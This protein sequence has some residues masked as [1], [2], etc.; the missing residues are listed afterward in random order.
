MIVRSLKRSFAS[1]MTASLVS[2]SRAFAPAGWD[3][4]A[5]VEAATSSRSV[6]VTQRQRWAL[7]FMILPF[8]RAV[9]AGGLNAPV[10]SNEAGRF[11]RPPPYSS[12]V[13]ALAF[14]YAALM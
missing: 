2:T 10:I 12:P 6:T 11:F 7:F 3:V 5:G 8:G 1:L 13:T 4:W 14:R 9:R